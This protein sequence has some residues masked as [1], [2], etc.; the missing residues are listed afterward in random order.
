VPLEPP[1]RD[2]SNKVV[3]HDHTGIGPHDGVIRRISEKQIVTDKDGRKR[4]SSKA[5]QPSSSID[6][7]M[8]VDLEVSILEA[9]LNPKSYVTTPRWTGSVR[10]EAGALR[11]EGLRVGFNPLPENP[12]HGEVWGD[13][14][15]ITEAPAS[16]ALRVVCP[17]RRRIPR[18]DLNVHC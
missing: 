4:L 7:G 8:S 2:A 17:Y 10:F 6:G 3:P 12:H 14:S 11:N 15:Q 13:F 1:P 5:F 18:T 9:G 16:T